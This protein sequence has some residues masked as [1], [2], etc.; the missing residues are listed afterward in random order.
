MPGPLHCQKLLHARLRLRQESLSTLKFGAL[1]M[2]IQNDT[3]R[4]VVEDD[5]GNIDGTVSRAFMVT[6]KQ[7]NTF[8]TN[9]S[10]GATPVADGIVINFKA[11]AALVKTLQAEGEDED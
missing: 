10:L 5:K 3:R 1:C 9:P 6:V 11:S 8:I 7:S 4:N 2:T